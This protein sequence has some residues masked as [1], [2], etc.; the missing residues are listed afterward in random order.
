MNDT[1]FTAL[2][3]RILAAFDKLAPYQL[4]SDVAALL[5]E[6]RRLRTENMRLR[7]ALAEYASADNWT[8]FDPEISPLL[9]EVQ[10]LGAGLD[11]WEVAQR[12]LQEPV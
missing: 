7:T 9:Q 4:R 1:Q 10:W 8:H 6:A 11:G 3:A 2:T 12:A 5:N